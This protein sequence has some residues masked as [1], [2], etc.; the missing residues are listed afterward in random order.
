MTEARCKTRLL[1]WEHTT[2]PLSQLGAKTRYRLEQGKLEWRVCEELSARQ[3]GSWLGVTASKVSETNG[4]G[5]K[6]E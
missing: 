3:V 4:E 5:E 2:Y 1:H 6:P